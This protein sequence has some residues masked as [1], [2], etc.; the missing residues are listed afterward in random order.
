MIKIT[1]KVNTGREDTNFKIDV[2]E[3]KY[4]AKWVGQLATK[5]P[6]SGW[7]G[8]DCPDIFYQATPP[9]E[10]YSNYFGLIT[11][12]G[13]AYITSGSTAV[14]GVIAGV[15]ADD[16]EIIYSRYRHDYR[17]ST[18]GSVFID[19][20]RDYTKGSM[21]GKYI[22]MKIVDGEWYQLEEDDLLEE[23][24]GLLNNKSDMPKDEKNV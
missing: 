6:V 19:G 15:V 21:H 10:G 16:G 8:D 11:R 24:Q 7:S 14:E 1:D 17:T 9:V 12:Q 3:K 23:A 20:G 22:S 18:D 5:S 2:V 13:T 4:N